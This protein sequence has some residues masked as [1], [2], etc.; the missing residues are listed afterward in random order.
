MNTKH[1]QYFLEIARQKNMNKAAESLYVSQ[2]SLSQY[3]SRL[4]RELGVLLFYRQKGNLT[5][6]PAGSIYYDY[7]RQVLELESRMQQALRDSVHAPRIRVGV[8]AIWGSRLVTSIAAGFHTRYPGTTLEIVEANH[9]LLKSRIAEG[10][11][12]IAVLATDSLAGLP[13][14]CKT[15]RQEEIVFA[16]PGQAP[17]LRE[18]PATGRALTMQELAAVFG[19]EPFILNKPDS[20]FRPLLDQ[21]FAEN[22]FR[23]SVLCEVSNMNTVL[24]MVSRGTGVAFIPASVMDG[25]RDIA[26]FSLSPRL[27]RCNGLL[28]RETLQ[29]TEAERYFISLVEQHPMFRQPH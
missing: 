7:A 10:S 13:G 12:D 18:H 1:L 17:Q 9:K 20:S 6:T 3:L 5:L 24:D 27:T 22:G 19:R 11:I 23:P 21:L 29:F 4:E 8:N 25:Q 28:C 2:S 26:Y 16:V 14:Y 15:L